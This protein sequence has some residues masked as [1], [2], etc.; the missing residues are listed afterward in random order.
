MSMTP[1]SS[2]YF[3]QVAG[4]WDSL[5]GGFFGEEVRRAAFAKAYLRSE[6]VA[7]D[8]GAGTGVMAAGLAPLVR[9]VHV[10]DGSPA[11]LEVARKNLA[12]FDNVEYHLADGQSLPFPDSS[13]DAVFANMYLHHC[14]DPLAAMREM[15]RVLKPGGRLV[16]TDA[17]AHNHT[18]MRE[19]MAD[20][21][22]GFEREQMRA[23][24]QEA[25]LVNVIVDCTGQS[26]CAESSNPEV[27]D[28]KGRSAK[29]S[30][31][32][33]TGTRRIAMR[34]Q[35][36]SA[37][38]AAATSS[39]GCG[40]TSEAPAAPGQAEASQASSS[41]CS[42][43]AE[44]S[45]CSESQPAAQEEAPSGIYST[46]ELSSAPAEA[47]EISLGCGNPIALANLRPGEVVLDIGSGGGLDSFL[48]AGKVGPSG[49][50]VGVDMTPAMLE[51]ARRSAEKA[52]I[53]NVE[54]RQ[55]Q[56]EA[57]PVESGTVDVILSNCVINLTED[58]G[59]VFR[60]AYRALKPGG[61]LEV[62]DIVTDAAI[63]LDARQDAGQWA[64]CVSG[65]L[66]EREYLDLIAQAGFKDANVKRSTQAGSGAGINFYS[67][68]ISAIKPG[69]PAPEPAQVSLNQQSGTEPRRSCCSG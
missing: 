41:C 9:Q 4:Q 37:Y 68:I 23:W 13:L 18:W 53:H 10:I 47:S 14:P 32:V 29:I 51:R 17:D 46:Q 52:G 39:C 36:Q 35:V 7:A 61:R 25:G 21:W 49:R 22:L 67:A 55:G 24:F 27:T 54:F 62:S 11:M 31:F 38:A 69:G 50:V 64:G 16:I 65:A 58:K 20:V 42:S 3:Q 12:A 26:C 8:V 34:Q 56:A 1:A 2:E 5:R 48:A 43:Q 60:E 33:A 15:A 40:S 44:A 45:C 59:L 63:P 66:P 6:M 30:I 19:E 57:L 28:E